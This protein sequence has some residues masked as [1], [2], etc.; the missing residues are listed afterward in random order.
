MKLRELGNGGPEVGEIGLGCMSFAGFYGPT[1][2]AESH[3]TLAAALDLGVTHLDTANVYGDGVSEEVI[4]AFIKDHPNRF[5]I[6]TKGS[7]WR[8]KEATRPINNTKE[9]LTEELDK[10][11]KRLGVDHV[12]LYYIH[13]R[14]QDIPI[15]DVME[16]LMGFKEA[17]KIGGI[18]FSE[19][20]PSSIR[21]AAAV[22]PVM[23]VQ[24]EYSLWTRL[25]ELG[26]IQA[27]RDVGAAFVPFSPLARGMFSYITPDPKSFGDVD[28][29]KTG[30]RFL[31]PNF[32]A[33]VVHFDR[34]RELSADLNISPAG[35]AIA[36]VL[37][38]GDHMIPIPGTRSVEHLKECVSG[39]GFAMTDD[40]RSEIDQIMPIG[41]AH[42]DRY[43][44]VQTVTAERYC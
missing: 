17:G 29:R 16:T 37:D 19:V 28:F 32:T 43:S 22:G 34:F 44:D 11:L 1:T 42:G 38:Q 6:A 15:E 33:N 36:W 39:S 14:Q 5:E 2:E 9:H 26:V 30:P 13:R 7:F 12:A 18:G 20:S 25:P 23:A 41:F 3:Q 27:C 10:S 40:V 21:R 31:E 24:S 4:G 35:L 8:A